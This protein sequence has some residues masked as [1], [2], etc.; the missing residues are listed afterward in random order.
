MPRGRSRYATPGPRAGSVLLDTTARRRRR[1]RRRGRGRGGFGWNRLFRWL[2][3]LAVLAAIGGGIYLWRA[4]ED[5][6]DARH[7][8][9][10]RFAAAWAKRDAKAMWHELTP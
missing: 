4:R 10:Q 3:G 1:R 9:A 7:A 2:L 6:I 8:A 5:A